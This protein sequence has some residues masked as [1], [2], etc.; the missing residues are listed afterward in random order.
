MK[1]Y[2]VLLI[3]LLNLGC[4]QLTIPDPIHEAV[5]QPSTDAAGDW[6]LCP[7]IR[8]PS[9]QGG[10]PPTV[11]EVDIMLNSTESI[12]NAVILLAHSATVDHEGGH[13]LVNPELPN[14][15]VEIWPPEA[16]NLTSWWVIGPSTPMPK[17]K[18]I[19][20]A[21]FNIE[22]YGWT[23][24]EL[25]EEDC[26]DSIYIAPPEEFDRREGIYDVKNSWTDGP[27]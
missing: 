23:W 5:E 24:F 21:E 4:M 6:V 26:R 16:P 15:R 18:V 11:V 7:R 22:A 20:T 1:K 2:T 17:D 12:G 10:N 27:H 3:C 19:F 25:G 14:H 13:E 8:L 9:T